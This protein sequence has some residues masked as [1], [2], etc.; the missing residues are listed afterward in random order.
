[1]LTSSSVVAAAPAIPGNVSNAVINNHGKGL[2]F[3]VGRYRFFMTGPP[4][5]QLLD[6]LATVER[7]PPAARVIT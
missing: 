1:M 7:R 4:C 2:M 5:V 6:I 3:L